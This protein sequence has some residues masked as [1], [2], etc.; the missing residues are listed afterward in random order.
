[1]EPQ[2]A[3]TYNNANTNKNKK[4]Y[5]SYFCHEQLSTSCSP[6]QFQISELIAVSYILPECLLY[7]SYM[8]PPPHMTCV[9]L[10]GVLIVPFI[11]VSSSSYDM[12]PPHMTCV[13]LLGVLIVPF[14]PPVT[15]TNGGL[16]DSD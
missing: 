8:Y 11:H 9:L 7:H 6:R 10:L 15:G 14:L 2:H 3:M 4:K 12:C 16:G 13:L 1:M 5:I